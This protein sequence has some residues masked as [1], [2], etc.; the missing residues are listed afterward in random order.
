MPEARRWRETRSR[1]PT[2]VRAM[3]LRSNV[4]VIF[5][6]VSLNYLSIRTIHIIIG[7]LST[8]SKVSELT[9]KDLLFR[10][11]QRQPISY[12]VFS[13]TWGSNI[14]ISS[15]HCST[16]VSLCPVLYSFGMDSQANQEC[17]I[18]TGWHAKAGIW[19][20]LKG[21]GFNSVRDFLQILFYNRSRI[22]WVISPESSR[23][24]SC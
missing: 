5:G 18:S 2:F 1:A 12:Q 7:T 8:L 14:L 13:P 21:T 22:L 23:W 24:I 3:N 19:R 9:R 20:L 4:Y 6:R 10:C 16:F 11:W 17:S 15:H